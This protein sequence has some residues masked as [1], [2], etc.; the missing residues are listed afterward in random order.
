MGDFMRRLP[1]IIGAGLVA[2]AT[3]SA[4]AVT[5][6]TAQ[7]PGE[8]TLTFVER[9]VP[10]NDVFADVPPLATKKHPNPGR[11]DTL[12]FDNT[13][14]DAS[15]ATKVGRFRAR[16]SFLK[17]TR[18]FVGSVAI[19]DAVYVLADGTITAIASPTFGPPIHFAVTGGTGAYE[20]ARGS[21]VSTNRPGANKPLSDTTIHLLP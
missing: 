4:I 20:G 6:G 10:A 9:S 2:A 19:C 14:L 8:R 13:V 15:G 17:A 21:G 18:R 11:G 5:S 3:A 16:C 12:L 1:T 7:A